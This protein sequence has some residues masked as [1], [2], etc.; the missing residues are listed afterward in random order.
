MNKKQTNVQNRTRDMKI[1]NKLT[2]TREEGDNGGNKEK[3]Q[4]KEHV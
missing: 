1:K 3:G 4:V 2:M